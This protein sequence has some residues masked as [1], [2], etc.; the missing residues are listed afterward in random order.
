MG[1]LVNWQAKIINPFLITISYVINNKV[2][3]LLSILMQVF[4]YLI[5]AHKSYILIPIAI[6]I[7]I[8]KILEKRNFFS[9]GIVLAPIGLFFSY[10]TYI[11]IG[12]L[13]I[14]SLFIRR[15]LFVPARIKFNYYDFFSKNKM[16]YFSEG[17]IGKILGISSPYEINAANLIGYLYD[18]NIGT[19]AN[20]GYLADAYANMGVFG[21]L[22]IS[23]LLVVIFLIINSFSTKINKEVVVGLS[24]FSIL[25]LNDGALLTTIFTGGLLL[26][27]VILFIYSS[28]SKKENE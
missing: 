27:L 16:L 4:I 1:Y 22:I 12:N 15:L 8:I 10:L 6:I 18:G 17:L 13:T 19:W 24:V 5:T 14:P 23:L 2:M 25:S 7:I 21:M 11:I 26:L 20:T 28:G 3:L 9:N